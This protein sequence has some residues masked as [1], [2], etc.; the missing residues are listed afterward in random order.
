[1][2][3]D[4]HG[5]SGDSRRCCCICGAAPFLVGA[6]VALA[7]GWWIFPDLIFSKQPQPFF[8]S[9]AVHVEKVGAACVDC[10]SFR[11]D[12][13]FTGL[14][15]LAACADCHSDIQ[16]AEPDAKSSPSERAAYAAEK[17]FVE[18]YV[19]DGKEVPWLA[20]QKQPDNVFFSHAAHFSRCY[21]C[22][23]T[24]KGRLNFGNPDNPRK[25]C[26]NCHP[27]LEELDRNAPVESNV[28]TG[29]G[30]TTKKMWECESCHAHPGHFSD[31]G[32]GRTA[33]NNACYTC[34]K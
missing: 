27:S 6:L 23:L 15:K 18:T 24:M 3:K 7:F 2:E 8:F 29:Y 16:T 28:L 5:A 13:S 10:H 11:G 25:L 32:K 34:H 9:H 4:K 14:P 19:R 30:R 12:G 1:M 17:H 20:H 21:S 33:A 31:D 22:H 26:M